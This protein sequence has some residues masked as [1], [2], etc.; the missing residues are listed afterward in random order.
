MA[1]AARQKMVI[2]I[3]VLSGD[4]NCW[5]RPDAT[6]T[7]ATHAPSLGRLGQPKRPGLACLSADHCRTQPNRQGQTAPHADCRSAFLQTGRFARAAIAEGE[8]VVRLGG[9]VLTD[10]EFRARDLV[11]C[12]SL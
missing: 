10:E 5:T 9:E 7:T 4:T 11:K 8:I 3:A 6:G 12:S 2:G 1:R